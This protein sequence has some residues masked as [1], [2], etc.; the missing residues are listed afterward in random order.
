MDG[1]RSVDRIVHDVVVELA[2]FDGA[3]R[4]NVVHQG[5]ARRVD[6]RCVRLH[7][8]ELLVADDGIGPGDVQ[9][10]RVATPEQLFRFRYRRGPEAGGEP[11]DVLADIVHQ[12]PAAVAEQGERAFGD[13]LAD[14]PEPVEAQA[15]ALHVEAADD[16]RVAAVRHPVEGVGALHGGQPLRDGVFGHRVHVHGS[17]GD[18]H[19]AARGAGDVDLIEADPPSR[20]DPQLAGGGVEVVGER[21][22]VGDDGDHAG[23][24]RGGEVGGQ[25]PHLGEPRQGLQPRSAG[26]A[27]ELRIVQLAADVDAHGPVILPGRRALCMP[28]YR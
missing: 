27:G 20:H 26:V 22:A 18:Q 14:A 13:L 21:G 17:D 7:E 3:V 10:H 8:G 23:R 12:Q 15:G 5:A 6:Q 16:P 25:L 1:A 2:L 9:A 11:V 24:V 4:R 19:A 28:T